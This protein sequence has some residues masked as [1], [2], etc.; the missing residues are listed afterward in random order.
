MHQKNITLTHLNHLE[1]VKIDSDINF[2]CYNLFFRIW[3]PK[4][5]FGTRVRL[6]D[7]SQ[8]LKGKS[9]AC[10]LRVIKVVPS[11]KS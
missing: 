10:I 1:N 9:V 5:R 7:Q 4:E 2:L 11:K 3:R 6:R 8:I